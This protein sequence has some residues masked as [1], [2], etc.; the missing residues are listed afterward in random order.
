MIVFKKDWKKYPNAIVDYKTRNESFLYISSLLRDIGVEHHYFPL[1]LLQ[2]Q[3]QGIDPFDETLPLEY[4]TMILMECDTNPWY[5]LREIASDRGAGP[6]IEEC[7]FKANRGN[8]AATW[9]TL[10]SINHI[11]QQPRQTGKSFETYTISDWLLYFGY[12]YTNMNL[13]TKDRTL[14]KDSVDKLKR[15]RDAWP[16]YLLRHSKSDAQNMETLTCNALDN[17]YQTHVSQNSENGAIKLGR[18][19][20]SPWLHF[21]EPP[22]M[23]H[24][25]TTV[26][27]AVGSIGQARE[28][29]KRKGLPYCNIYTTTSGDK[30]SPSGYYFYNI[31][32]SAAIW[33]DMYYDVADREELVNIIRTNSHSRSPIVNLTFNHRQLGYSDEW[34][35]ETIAA[36]H[37]ESENI[38]RDFFNRWTSS[39]HSSPLDEKT[40]ARI[41]SS[42]KSPI[43][44][45]VSDDSYIVNWYD[46]ID[47][48]QIYIAGLDTSDAIGRD[49]ITLVIIDPRSGATVGTGVYNET[50]LMR[51]TN[52]LCQFMVKHEN[53]VLIPERRYNAQNI[54]DGLLLKLPENKQDPFKRIYSEIT[55]DMDKHRKT[56]S[57]LSANA[58]HQPHQVY[59]SYRKHFGF[60]TTASSR[61]ILY[62]KVFSYATKKCYD[63]VYDHQLIHQIL[64]LTVK[65]GRID[66]KNGGNDDLV[67]SWLLCHYFL[68]YGINL[69]HY[70]IDSQKIFKNISK[71][72]DQSPEQ[73]YQIK[74]QR[75]I[76]SKIEE[77]YDKLKNETNE[78]NIKRYENELLSL[79]AKRVDVEN[80]EQT[81]DSLIEKAKKEREN[82]IERSNI[83]SSN[84]HIRA[85][86]RRFN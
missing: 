66:H 49:D 83:G 62:G 45:E 76:E 50:N 81:I 67:I 37:T 58:I 16:S 44:L 24:L 77:L 42:E 10:A 85:L 52:W 3:L 27:A 46:T 21:D 82:R 75:E 1:A 60:Q 51:F 13:I 43:E 26:S 63:V 78:M 9:L 8:I 33:R 86:V 28:I 84:R 11:R 38:D 72:N 70:G 23:N 65:N 31:L 39:A 61:N 18:G 74:Q 79:S 48:N 30:E 35:Y 68:S 12:T 15:I 56:Y 2:P 80:E 32:N 29:A 14:R 64:N 34:L 57:R 41:R 71:N 73:R 55:Q 19:L 22:F 54:I 53:I 36:T 5:F 47:R 25:E 4:K 40:A 17:K 59:E 69:S 7:L 20:T 6:T